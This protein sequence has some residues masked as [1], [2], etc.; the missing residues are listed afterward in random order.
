MPGRRRHADRGR[1]PR[2]DRGTHDRGGA[3]GHEG[4]TD[5]KG[6][7][8]GGAPPASLRRHRGDP[9]V[10]GDVMGS[11][12]W[13]QLRDRADELRRTIEGELGVKTPGVVQE[14]P[15]DRGLF[16]VATFPWAKELRAS[17]QEIAAPAPPVRSGVR[18][19]GE[20]YGRAPPR[21]TRILLEHTSVN[22][23]GPLHVGRARNPIFGDSL[24]RLLR[25]AGYQVEREYFVNDIGKQ[26][27]IMYWAVTHLPPDDADAAEERI[28]RRYVKLYQRANAQL[29]KDPS[30]TKEIDLLIRRCEG[31][32]ADLPKAIRAVGDKV[33]KRILEVLER[34][35][36]A[37][38]SFADAVQ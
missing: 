33:L 17:P 14:A 5:F 27:V 30:L 18:S 26:M 37:F 25:Y 29:E 23:T 35:D 11:D 13:S 38:D 20:D 36:I 21:S 24:G 10:P 6:L 2:P 3:D 8:G 12:P 31:G 1:E 9:P 28:E 4:R 15:E 32:D 16:A 7:R 34:L 19:R 22:P